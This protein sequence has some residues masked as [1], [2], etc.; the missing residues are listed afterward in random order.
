MSDK[1]VTELV[2]WINSQLT[3][4]SSSLSV[5]NLSSDLASGVRLIQLLEVT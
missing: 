4:R 1:L 3:K 2:T 5:S